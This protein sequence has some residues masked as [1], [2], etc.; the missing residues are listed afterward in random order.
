MG[1]P[2]GA[3][4]GPPAHHPYWDNDFL[5]LI[6]VVHGFR[7]LQ[8]GFYLP[9]CFTWIANQ[10]CNAVS[11]SHFQWFHPDIF[12]LIGVGQLLSHA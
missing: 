4:E 6:S 12:G 3:V 7:V 8:D 5:H 9:A 11:S 10:V 2:F 1:T